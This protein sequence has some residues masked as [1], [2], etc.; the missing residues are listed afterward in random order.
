MG[1]LRRAFGIIIITCITHSRPSNNNYVLYH[2]YRIGYYVSVQITETTTFLSDLK[3]SVHVF[4]LSRH[5][6]H[7]LSNQSE[8]L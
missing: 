4:L 2:Y 1:G 6:T 8:I 7:L 3:M 5:R